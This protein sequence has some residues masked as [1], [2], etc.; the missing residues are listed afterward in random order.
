[1]GKLSFVPIMDFDC[2]KEIEAARDRHVPSRQ[3]DADFRGK[4]VYG[5]KRN[6]SHTFTDRIRPFGRACKNQFAG[7]DSK[8]G[9]SPQLVSA[10]SAP[11]L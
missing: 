10:F 8:S 4:V 3:S 5:S 7:E 9:V 11:T 1:M 6:S 2:P